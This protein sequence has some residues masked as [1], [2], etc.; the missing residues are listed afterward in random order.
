MTMTHDPRRDLRRK[1]CRG[2]VRPAPFSITPGIVA[3]VLALAPVRA[4]EPALRRPEVVHI[5]VVRMKLVDQPRPA[6][7]PAEDP[8]RPS[9][10]AD[11][12]SA[13]TNDDI[14]L[15]Q[16]THDGGS[17]EPARV[18]PQ[19]AEASAPVEQDKLDLPD[20]RELIRVAAAR[21]NAQ[22]VAEKARI[23]LGAPVPK[24]AP[25]AAPAP[26]E[27]RQRQLKGAIAWLKARCVL[28]TPLDRD[29]LVRRYRVS[30]FRDNQLA[31]DVV[32][33][34]AAQGFEVPNG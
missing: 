25:P 15:Q 34:A 1:R 31:E 19:Q 32:A 23:P 3:Q 29:A 26:F 2:N 13:A 10:W 7:H 11:G 33:L 28:V 20:R 18:A 6:D 22:R 16:A 17:E 30:G 12:K 9:S 21:L 14:Q 24:V 8:T 27:L 4:A 5:P